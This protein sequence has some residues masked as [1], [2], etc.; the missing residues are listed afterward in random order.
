MHN[1]YTLKILRGNLQLIVLKV[2]VGKIGNA[3]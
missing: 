1:M 3:R 2:L